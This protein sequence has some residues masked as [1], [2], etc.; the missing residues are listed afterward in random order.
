LTGFPCQ[1]ISNAGKPAGITG[2]HSSLW[3]NV[4]DAVRALHPPL[5]FVEFS[6]QLRVRYALSCAGT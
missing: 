6:G 3:S 1:D 4:V 2:T 5:V